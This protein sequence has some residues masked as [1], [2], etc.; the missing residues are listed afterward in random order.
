MAVYRLHRKEWEKGNKQRAKT[1]ESVK[2]RKRDVK[3]S[4]LHPDGD[5]RGDGVKDVFPG[6][7]LK[8]V[9]S[10]LSTVVQRGSK[11]WDREARGSSNTDERKKWWKELASGSKETLRFRKPG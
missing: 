9:S 8:G 3:D 2:K 11:S 4:D 1:G 7:G 10:G 5:S 6:G